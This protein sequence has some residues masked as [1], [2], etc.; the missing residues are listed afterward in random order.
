MK[1]KNILSKG[2]G[3]TALSVLAL[4]SSCDNKLDID[5][6]QSIGSDVALSTPEGVQT[7]LIGAYER[8]Q[9][10]QLYGTNLNLV[11]E[12]LAASGAELQWSGTFLGYRQLFG[13]TTVADNSEATRTWIRAY[14]T[15]NI[16]NNVIASVDVFEDET[17]RDRVLGEALFIRGIVYF[18]LIQLYGLP[19][20]AGNQASNPGVPLILEPTQAISDADNVSRASVADVYAQLLDDLT[21]AKTLLPESNGTRANTYV[22]SAFLARVY[23]QQADASNNADEAFDMAGAE[24]DRVIESGKYSLTQNYTEAFN[25]AANISEYVFAIQQNQQS[26]AGSSNDGLATFY[27]DFNG[28]GRGD[29]DLSPNYV[30]NLYAEGDERL[31]VFYVDDNGVLRNG[32]YLDPFTNIAVIRVAEMYLIR[33]EAAF[34]NGDLEQA[35]EDINTVRTRANLAPLAL[36]TLED[37]LQER[38][39]ELAFEGLALYDVKRLRNSVGNLAYNAPKLVLPIPQR[40]IDVNPNITQNPSY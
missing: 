14:E 36:V 30:D 17:T 18:E 7:A 6:Q 31:D 27:A 26:N 24:A 29:V 20:S 1:L 35:L 15:I 16:A 12:L 13:K 3:F 32:K 40:E 21:R 23:L 22:A 10:G 9:G 38:R 37:I 19:W 8:L 39:R 33:A 5:P 25:N 2:L 28:V 4:V 11:S 34:R